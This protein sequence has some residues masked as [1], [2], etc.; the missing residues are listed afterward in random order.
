M[1]GGT[2]GR[3]G[4]LQ[5]VRESCLLPGIRGH[6]PG[7]GGEGP[8][9]YVPIESLED[10]G[11]LVVFTSIPPFLPNAA[12]LPF[13]SKPPDLFIGSLSREPSRPPP[14]HNPSW[15]HALQLV[16]VRT[17][18]RDH[19]YKLMLHTLHFLT[20][21]SHP[22][23]KWRDYLLPEEA[24]VTVQIS[25][26]EVTME[27]QYRKRA[28]AWTEWEVLD[29]IAVWEDESVLSELRSKRRNAKIFEKISKS[30]KDRGYNRDPQQC[31]V[32]LKELRQTYQKTTDANACLG[33]EPQ[34]CRFYDELHAILG[35]GP[36]TTPHLYMDSCK[37]VSHNRDED[38]G[39]EEDDEE[40]EVEH[41]AHQASG[42]TILPDSQEL[43]ITLEP[44]PSQPSQPGLPDLEGREGTSAP[45]VSTLPLASP[46]QRL[47][48]VRRRKTRTRD[49]MFSE[50]MQSSRTERAQENAWRQTMSEPRKAQNEH[51]NRRDTREDRWLD[52]QERWQ[53]RDETG[54]EAMLRLLE[55]QTDMLRHM[56]EVQERHRSPLQ[57]PSSIAS[58]P[59]RPRMRG[60]GVWAPNHATPEDCPSNRRLAF[61]KF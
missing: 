24:Q 35:G 52:Q 26:A 20:L 3:G 13:L 59:R 53:Q 5:D 25:S 49:E 1:S 8:G 15:L 38:F 19:L 30:M 61:N 17:T 33:S 7:D 6:C 48:Q 27:S 47:A 12:L 4:G 2:H 36:T 51:E 23:T 28:P 57:P 54:Q 32:K 39:D 16:H 40:G 55:D 31:H 58:S 29:L 56:V 60:G 21:V 34:T 9:I 18:P 44:I 14:F 45:N 10:L 50:L 46:S 41:S 22:D 11:I 42:E 43:F 37:G